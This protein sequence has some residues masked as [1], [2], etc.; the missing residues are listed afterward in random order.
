MDGTFYDIMHE[1]NRLIL[2]RVTPDVELSS[3]RAICQSWRAM[4]LIKG[5]DVGN[6][7]M[8]E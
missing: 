7:T 2:P 1:G 8:E 3:W 6:V 5:E 4:R